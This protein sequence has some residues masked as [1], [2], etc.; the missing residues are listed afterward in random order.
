MYVRCGCMIMNKIDGLC[1]LGA[2]ILTYL[3]IILDSPYI[4][5]KNFPYIQS[6]VARK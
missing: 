6:I 1:P 4:F 3:G 5:F 2:Y